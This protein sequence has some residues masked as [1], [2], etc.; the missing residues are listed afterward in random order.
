MGIDLAKNTF[1]LHGVDANG[2]IYGLWERFAE[3]PRLPRGLALAVSRDGGR[4]F[5]AG[6]VPG[7]AGAGWNGSS[8]GLLMR[9]R[10]RAQ[11]DRALACLWDEQRSVFVLYE[12]EGFSVPEIADLLTLPLGTAAS[13]LG[14]ARARFA[15]AV[16]RLD[17]AGAGL[18]EP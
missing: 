9:K 15:E 17:R 16:E 18:E 13:R 11:L 3:H 10:L 6:E 12:L 1:S 8:Q 14:R 5:E 7:S 4:T 2:R